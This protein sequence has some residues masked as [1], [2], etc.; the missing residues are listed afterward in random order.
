VVTGALFVA[1]ALALTPVP[2]IQAPVTDAAGV[3]S[4]EAVEELDASLRAHRDATGVQLAV[5]LVDTTDGE[6]IEDFALRAA[7][8]WGGG[9]K[10]KD[11]GGLFVL[12]VKDRR[13]RLEL[14]YGLEPLVPDA[15][16]ASVLDGLKPALR[17]GDYDGAVRGLVERLKAVTRS[18]VAAPPTIAPPPPLV[19]GWAGELLGYVNVPWVLVLAVFLVKIG[20]AHV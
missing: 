14:G 12:A 10:R 19:G 7:M 2:P 3:L 5:L 16:A 4:A 8:A 13:M 9:A 18:G 17:A 1:V 15:L 6:P 20:R 11:D